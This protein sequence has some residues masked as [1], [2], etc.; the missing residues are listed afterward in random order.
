M[1]ISIRNVD[2]ELFKEFKA[3]AVRE[4]LSVGKAL[5]IAIN[6]WLS[7]HTKPKKSLLDLKTKRWGKGTENTSQEIDKILY[8]GKK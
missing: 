3:E 2:E 5:N 6:D 4:G 8:G 7:K 1:A